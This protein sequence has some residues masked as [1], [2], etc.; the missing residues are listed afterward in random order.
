VSA[1]GV[2]AVTSPAERPIHQRHADGGTA[3]TEVFFL[4]ITLINAAKGLINK[5]QLLSHR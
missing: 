5:S 2:L 1:C 4:Q 3:A